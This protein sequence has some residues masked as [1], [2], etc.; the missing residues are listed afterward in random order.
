MGPTLATSTVF[1]KPL[2]T[3]YSMVKT[4]AWFIVASSTGLVFKKHLGSS[5]LRG[6]EESCQL[7]FH[8]TSHLNNLSGSVF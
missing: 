5:A 7:S 2:Q 6:V 8:E 1:P 4:I 3:R